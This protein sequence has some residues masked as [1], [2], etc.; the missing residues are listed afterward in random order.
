LFKEIAQTEKCEVNYLY[1]ERIIAKC[2]KPFVDGEFVKMCLYCA[3]DIICPA[4]KQAV[5]NVSLLKDTI[6]KQREDLSE[7]IIITFKSKCVNF[8]FYSVAMDESS[9]AIDCAVSHLRS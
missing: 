5:S 8:V 3:L 6:A 2:G 1:A 7:N 9:D 4:Q